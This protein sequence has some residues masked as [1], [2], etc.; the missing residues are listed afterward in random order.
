[1][2]YVFCLLCS[3]KILILRVKIVQ[4]K[5]FTKKY[6]A[7]PHFC[8]SANLTTFAFFTH[9]LRRVDFDALETPKMQRRF[10]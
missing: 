5:W 4:I 3:A 1:M 7:A 6:T 2:L 10:S 9:F 8:E